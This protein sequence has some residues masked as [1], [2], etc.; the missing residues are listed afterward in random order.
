MVKLTLE[1]EYDP[2]KRQFICTVI[3]TFGRGVFR[4]HALSIL[5]GRIGNVL[6]DI[7]I[8]DLLRNRQGEPERR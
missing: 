7:G 4:G 6:Y 2:T 1:L 8:A 5:L 3:S